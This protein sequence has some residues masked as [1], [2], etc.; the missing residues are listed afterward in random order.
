MRVLIMIELRIAMTTVKRQ[1]A[2]PPVKAEFTSIAAYS[3]RRL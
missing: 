1:L 3:R 2:A